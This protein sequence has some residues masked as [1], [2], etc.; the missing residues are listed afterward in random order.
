[1]SLEPLAARRPLRELD[2]ILDPV[3]SYR[4]RVETSLQECVAS[5]E[6]PILRSVLESV[7]GGPAKR[8][9]PAITLL[10]G[11]G[12]RF[13]ED[14]LI[15]LAAGVEVLHSATLVHDD[16]VDAADS[17]RGRLAVH[18]AWSDKVAILAGDYLFATSAD[19]VARLDRP[20]IV[21]QFADTIRLMSRSEFAA[22]VLD[23]GPGAARL[24]YLEKIG[25]KT[26][27]LIALSCIA[28][29]VLVDVDDAAADALQ[30]FGWALGMAF[31]ITDDVLDVAGEANETGKPV[32]GDLR[33]GILTLPTIEYMECAPDPH[34]SLCKLAHGEPM[35]E[36]E[37]SVAI[38]LLDSSGALVAARD[39]AEQF[40]VQARTALERLPSNQAF[41]ALADLVTYATDRSR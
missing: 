29:G 13:E 2:S 41:D 7:L 8:L 26:A 10:V 31:Q 4:A 5:G 1:M 6:I 33:A 40:S 21:R 23:S 24:Q 36:D 18:M 22:P 16:I 38:Q 20:R 32:G 30:E 9:R 37:V 14:D 11:L 34:P 28:T 25:N 39:V 12:Y 3:S 27:S 15:L 19:M 35:S 17:R